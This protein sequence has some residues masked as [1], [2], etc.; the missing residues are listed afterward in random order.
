MNL[1]LNR[2]YDFFVVAREEN[3]VRLKN[4]KLFYFFSFSL[5]FL[6]LPATLSYSKSKQTDSFSAS[7]SAQAIAAKGTVTIGEPIACSIKIRFARDVEILSE[8]SDPQ[9]SGLEIKNIQSFAD[10]EGK[11]KIITK[12]FSVTGYQLGDFMIEP[13]EI[14]YRIRGGEVQTL[15][16]NPLYIKIK[17]VAEGDEKNDIRD[18][19]NVVSLPYKI[20]KYL[21]WVG[22][23]AL[24]AG[25]LVAYLLYFRKREIEK[26]NE[27]LKLTPA[28]EALQELHHLF[29]SSLIRD[30]N[31]KQYYL[32][33]SEIIRIFLEKQFGIQAVE[34]TT[35]EIATLCKRLFLL[36]DDT[37]KR[38]IEVLDAAD[39]AKF[40][41][42]IPE[43]SDIL[44]L[45][46][47]A[48]EMILELASPHP[49]RKDQDAVS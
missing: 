48:E 49:L 2:L 21:L 3:K 41:K 28:E 11:Q 24:I 15:K 30:G 40:A 29:D 44:A 22:I 47:R 46:K 7:I 25:L 33:F 36:N 13:I 20:L 6:A 14:S 45:N 12:R 10:K 1:T 31:V 16:T 8:I 39:F 18:V 4:H 43:P 37:K 38:L 17:S 35:S 5:L 23:P 27:K 32:R 26:N 19:K 42:W 9:G 34:A